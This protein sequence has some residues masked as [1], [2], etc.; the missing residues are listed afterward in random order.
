MERFNIIESLEKRNL[1]NIIETIL[2]LLQSYDIKSLKLTCKKNRFIVDAYLWNGSI[3]MRNRLQNA[4][5]A[6]RCRDFD[7]RTVRR[8]RLHLNPFVRVINWLLTE[9]EFIAVE[10]AALN[11]GTRLSVYDIQTQ[12]KVFRTDSFIRE[13]DLY[14][15]GRRLSLCADSKV[16]AVL[17]V[18]TGLR[19]MCVKSG[20]VLAAVKRRETPFN[21][22]LT[23]GVRIH[24]SHVFAIFTSHNPENRRTRV[25]IYEQDGVEGRF[26]SNRSVVTIDQDLNL[27]SDENYSRGRILLVRNSGRKKNE[28]KLQL[29]PLIAD[30]ETTSSAFEY[31]PGNPRSVRIKAFDWPFAL[32]WLEA[33]RKIEVWNVAKMRLVARIDDC[34]RNCLEF[35]CWNFRLNYIHVRI[36]ERPDGGFRILDTGDNCRRSGPCSANE[37]MW[38]LAG[39]HPNAHRTRSLRFG[40]ERYRNFENIFEIVD[41]WPSRRTGLLS[42]LWQDWSRDV[43]RMTRCP[44][45][46]NF[47]ILLYLAGWLL[48]ANLTKIMYFAWPFRF[49]SRYS[50]NH[51]LFD[52]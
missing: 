9:T 33:F 10:S 47:V 41:Y 49:T 42:A 13:D 20:H 27:I 37:G 2:S 5:L 25:N 44:H 24:R 4:L 22:L 43:L 15:D 11:N 51:S 8:F 12:C 38:H 45:E 32:I 18:K 31:F 29:Y 7:R 1:V 46:V 34:G 52:Q 16:V 50:F 48:M 6:N 30:D 35:R 23:I 26:D 19:V 21:S 14:P 28:A 39:T 3:Q 40:A 17:G 36:I